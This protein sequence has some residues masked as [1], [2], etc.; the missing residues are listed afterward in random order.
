MESVIDLVIFERCRIG[1]NLMRFF[2]NEQLIERTKGL[3]TSK[4]HNETPQK[5][6]IK[7]LKNT[8]QNTSK[9]HNETPQKRTTKHSGK[10]VMFSI[11]DIKRDNVYNRKHKEVDEVHK[12]EKSSI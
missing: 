6:T 11:I 2:I 3:L 9:M 7:Y 8:Q 5:R 10:C 4:M 12:N 1:A